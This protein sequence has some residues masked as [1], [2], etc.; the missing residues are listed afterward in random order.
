MVAWVNDT[1]LIGTFEPFLGGNH[2]QIE[3]GWGGIICPHQLPYLAMMDGFLPSSYLYSKAGS[4]VYIGSRRWKKNGLEFKGL[5]QL[6]ILNVWQRR[7]NRTVFSFNLPHTMSELALIIPKSPKSFD[8]L[9]F[10]FMHWTK[11]FP[12][13]WNV[14][15]SPFWG[16][17]YITL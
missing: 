11:L 2:L 12:K 5:V 9:E 4:W 1:Y 10:L 8:H 16:P 13:N 17:V 6:P 14:L 15:V 7:K 3:S